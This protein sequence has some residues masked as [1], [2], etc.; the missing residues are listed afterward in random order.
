MN[1]I[2]RADGVSTGTDIIWRAPG[3]SAPM[4]RR[5]TDAQ[6][7]KAQIERCRRLAGQ[8]TDKRGA[9]ALRGLAAECEAALVKM[10][11]APEVDT[12]PDD[13]V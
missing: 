1:M 10:P 9:D 8:I 5:V 11:A 3:E 12:P 6:F 7:L 2:S 13:P 4:L